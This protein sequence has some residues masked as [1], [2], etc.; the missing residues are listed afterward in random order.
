MNTHCKPNPSPSM[1]AANRRGCLRRTPTPRIP[2]P[3]TRAARRG[4]TYVMILGVSMILMVIGLAAIAVTRINSRTVRTGN[5][6]AEAQVLAFSAVEH[7]LKR[8]DGVSDWRTRFKG[9]ETKIAFGRGTLSWKLVDPDDGDLADD[10]QDPFQI[11]ARGAVN[12]AAFAVS[13][14]CHVSGDSLKALKTCLH[15]AGN[16]NVKGKGVVRIEGGPVSTNGE[17]NTAKNSRITG[18]VEAASVKGK[19]KIDGSVTVPAPPKG[20]PDP[21]LFDT[22]AGMATSLGARTKVDKIILSPSLNPYGRPN[23]D[24]VYLIDAPGKNVTIRDSLIYGTLVVRCKKLTLDKHLLVRN[25][26]SQMPA[27]IVDGDV[28]LSLSIW[29]PGR[30]VGWRGGRNPWSGL[31]DKIPNIDGLMHVRGDLKVH[32]PA[33]LRG[34]ILCEGS[35]DWNTDAKIILDRAI[36]EDP[37]LGYST[38][39]GAICCDGCTRVVN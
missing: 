32:K 16:I 22:Y 21:K 36:Q 17:L 7:A 29:K 37:P 11:V 23:P 10:P 31:R 2:T 27:L 3:Y 39:G 28:D 25:A 26:S 13:M 24:G 4:S 9:K 38:G 1:S 19:G 14:D 20:S 30:H 5:D 15:S 33:I 35:V 18:D 12:D 8:I 34:A 6:W